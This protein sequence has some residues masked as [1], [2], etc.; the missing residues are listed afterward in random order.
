M[1]QSEVKQRKFVN[2]EHESRDPEADKIEIILSTPS[3]LVL[4]GGL[5]KDKFAGYKLSMLNDI[6]YKYVGDG[7]EK[8]DKELAFVLDR[9]MT[10][11]VDGH[12][13]LFGKVGKKAGFRLYTRIPV[14]EIKSVEKTLIGIANSFEEAEQRLY[15]Y[16]KS[17]ADIR[18]FDYRVPL[19]ENRN[20]PG[21]VW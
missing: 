3:E 20:A 14:G 11:I 13:C 2:S 16:V 15:E 6:V 5:I 10:E 18:A 21:C 8:R 19:R 17:W 7:E 12:I 1:V 4:V 9:C